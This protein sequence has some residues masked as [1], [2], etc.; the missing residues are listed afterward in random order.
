MSR[1][2]RSGSRPHIHTYRCTA[3]ACIQRPVFFFSKYVASTPMKTSFTSISKPSKT[4]SPL[5]PHAARH[6]SCRWQHWQQAITGDIHIPVAYTRS[7]EHVKSLSR[8]A[9]GEGVEGHLGRQF[10]IQLPGT[11]YSSTRA[12]LQNRSLFRNG[13]DWRAGEDSSLHGLDDQRQR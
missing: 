4:A 12:S 8:N 11:R 9:V 3:A 2:I 7:S 10:E 1:T 5:K 6:S 13:R